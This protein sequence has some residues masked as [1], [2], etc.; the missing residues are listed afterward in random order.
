[1]PVILA[2]QEVEIGRITVR[3][4]HGQKVPEAPPSQPI[5]HWVWWHIP[6]KSTT[7]KA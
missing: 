3:D 7:R 6:V 4:Q 1:M 2:I 5:K